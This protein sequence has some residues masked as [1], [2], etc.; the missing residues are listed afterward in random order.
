MRRLAALL[1][2]VTA[3]LWVR[4]IGPAAAVGSA[5]TALALGFTLLGAWVAGDLLRRFQLPRLTGYLLFGLL[6]G[7][8][9]GNDIT[10]SMAQQLQAIT[11]LA[12][13]LIA[14]IAG[15]SLNV[16]RLGRRLR[17]IAYLTATTLAVTIAGLLALAWLA[18]PWLGI[19][20]GAAGLEKLAMVLLLVVILVSF[21]PTMTVAVTAE[22]GARGRLSELVLAIVVLADLAVCVLFSLA[23]QLARAASGTGGDEVNVLARFAWEI[24]GAAAFGALA[25][26]LFALYMRYIARE[27][28]LALIV[29][30]GILSQVGSTQEF[31]PLLAALAAGLVIE[32]LA[33]AQGDALKAAVQ[34]GAPPILLI[35]FV[36][37]G[38][39]LQFDALAAV[40]ILAVA[41]AAVRLGLIRIGLAAGLRAARVEREPGRHAWTGLISQA[42]ITLGF[43][44]I[45]AATATARMP[46]A[47][48][49]SSRSE[50]PTATKKISRIGGAPRWTAALSAS[51]WATARFSITSPAASAASSGSN[52]CVLPTW[53]RM[54]HSTMSASVISRA[55]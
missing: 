33:V 27:I 11:G 10:E 8:Y 23:M 4:Q 12:T 52:S 32:N 39:S 47:A 48:S 36:A 26:A 40:G 49:A 37:V 30:C 44:S 1:L 45:V 13:T 7:P 21:S 29:L 53:L 18:W 41:V 50:V 15:L 54:P 42:G 3:V 2:A 25:G 19:A 38:T 6:A 17:P 14:L 22:T 43:G 5:G 35:F 24:G 34:R 9:L 55:M 28:T 51:P 20:P 16:E 46:T 31:E